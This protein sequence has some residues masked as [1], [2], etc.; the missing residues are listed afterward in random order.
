LIFSCDALFV[1]AATQ[2]AVYQTTFDFGDGSPKIGVFDRQLLSSSLKRLTLEYPHS[3][4]H[5]RGP[6]IT[7][8]IRPLQGLKCN[9]WCYLLASMGRNGNRVEN[10]IAITP[11]P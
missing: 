1:D 5:F 11:K 3:D 10:G 6:T 4:E 7:P 8:S 2:I 9:T